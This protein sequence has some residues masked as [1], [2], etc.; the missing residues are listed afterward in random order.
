MKLPFRELAAIGGFANSCAAA[1]QL[2]QLLDGDAPP[3][4]WNIIITAATTAAG[5]GLSAFGWWRKPPP[6][7]AAMPD[8]REL[9]AATDRLFHHFADDA[10][11]LEAVRVVARAVTERRYREKRQEAR[12]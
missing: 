10:A 11:A 1:V 8:D 3:D 4:V 2:S 12:D 9:L 6:S 7:I 5:L